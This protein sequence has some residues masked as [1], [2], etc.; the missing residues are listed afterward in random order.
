MIL[1]QELNQLDRF[2]AAWQAIERREQH[3]L[4]ELKSMATV[5]SVGASTRIEGSH[6]SDKEVEVLIENLDIT[7]LSDRDKQEVAGYFETLNLVGESYRDINVSES[8][9]KHLH[10]SLMRFS[11]KDAYHKGNYKNQ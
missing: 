11:D 10:N 8:G 3:T 5:K 4:K 6:L 9:I 2:D 1:L 7:K